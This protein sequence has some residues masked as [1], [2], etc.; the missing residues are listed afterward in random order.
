MNMRI[1]SNDRESGIISMDFTVN[2]AEQNQ[3]L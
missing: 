1:N 2:S 3:S